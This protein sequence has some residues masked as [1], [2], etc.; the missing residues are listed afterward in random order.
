M[1]Q[2]SESPFGATMTQDLPLYG[3]LL[4]GYLGSMF[5]PNPY[6]EA[7]KQM[8]QIP[9]ILHHYYDPYVQEGQ[10]DIGALHGEY[11]RLMGDPG[12]FVARMG[13]GFK[14]DPGYKYAVDQATGAANRA[15]AAGGMLGSPE[16]QANLASRIAG[17]AGQQYGDY[18][19]RVRNA[20]GAGLQGMGNL[21]RQGFG[22]AQGMGTSLADYLASR[23]KL[24]Q[25]QAESGR[26]QQAGLGATFG[27]LAGLIGGFL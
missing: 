24:A 12:G 1:R 27:S 21:E 11:G 5:G 9:G 23:A 26:Q 15:A 6:E 14:A 18:Y 16:E 13:S 10:R 4:G 19:N 25:A 7:G 22:A 8:G 2:E 20:Y 17:M 3:G